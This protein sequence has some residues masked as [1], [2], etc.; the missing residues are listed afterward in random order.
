MPTN[1]KEAYVGILEAPQYLPCVSLILPFEPK[2]SLE[3]DLAYQLKIAVDKIENE[4]L[5]NYPADKAIPVIKKLIRQIKGLNYNTHKSSIAIFISPI[6]EKVYYLDLPVE[7]KII[8]DNS[9]EIRD[10]I[11]SKKQIHKYL[12]AELSSKW[13]KIYLGNGSG[14]VPIVL[15]MPTNA[16]A[17]K[18]EL[19]EKIT[20]F[21]DEKKVKEILLDKF[22][23]HI[24]K[25]LKLLLQAY[26]LPLFIMG[27]PKTIGHFK[28]ITHN[29]NH[30]IEYIPGNFEKKTADELQQIMEPF[31]ADW[32]KIIQTDLL[33]QIE[34]AR[35]QKKIVT[36]IKDVWN[37]A[38]QK[39][40]RLLIVEYNFIY[41][42]E[43]S[44]RKE[45]IFKQ[46]ESSKNAFYI[47][48]A[49]DD[50]I[51]KVLASGG[52][53]EFVDEGLLKE[54]NKIVLI[55]YYRDN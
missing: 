1:I 24:D 32:K 19:S 44:S 18:K 52:D 33:H 41:P 47:K 49:V 34:D 37:V 23:Q 9:F 51:E 40:G 4:L 20:N 36:G 16:E 5:A 6:I 39:R 48:D 17:Y 12:L 13:I 45:I 43:Q 7:E 46:D 54:F 53:V 14:F 42:A 26:K 11:Y 38:T 29:A 55:E 8:I 30:V 28:A 10:L 22:L 35:S 3:K 27:A 25:G 2:M 15:N 21:S 31:V 50:V